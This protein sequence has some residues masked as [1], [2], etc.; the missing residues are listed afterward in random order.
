MRSPRL[1]QAPTHTRYEAI[2][3]P[4]GV[5]ILVL[6]TYIPLVHWAR[7]KSMQRLGNWG[8]HKDTY[9]HI[10]THYQPTQPPTHPTHIKTCM[11]NRCCTHCPHFLIVYRKSF[12]DSYVPS[13]VYRAT[14]YRKKHHNNDRPHRLPYI[15]S[16]IVYFIFSLVCVC[17]RESASEI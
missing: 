5:P 10:Y 13:I 16:Y 11:F 14:V 4:D 6:H 9:P 8:A 3:I 7:P 1:P 15:V 12:I 2:Y 17:S